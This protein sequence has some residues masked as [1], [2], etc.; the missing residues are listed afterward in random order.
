MAWVEPFVYFGSAEFS[1]RLL[2]G[3]IEADCKP[4]LVISTSAKPAGRGWRET[5]TPVAAYAKA[6]GLPV[7]T[8]KSLKH[9]LPQELTASAAVFG[10][11][12]AFGKIIPEGLLTLYPQGII[13]VHPSLLP[14]YRGPAPIAY[15]LMEGA[16]ETGVSIIKLDA[17]VDHGLM[18]AQQSLVIND[19]DDAV[20]LEQRLASLALELLLASV[21]KYLAGELSLTTQRHAQATYSHIVKRAHGQADWSQTAEALNNKRRAF[22]PWPGLWT[23][24]QGKRLKLIQTSCRQ[25]DLTAPGKVQ[26]IQSD[27]VIGCGERT[28]LIVKTIQLESGRVQTAN[29]FVR[30]RKDFINSHLP[31]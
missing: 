28:A 18:L 10:L 31:S 25:L 11:L 8:V 2:A 23:T 16:K 19:N 20:G 7:V 4:A 27:L 13:N 12:A 1:R 30:G 26:L 15:A 22:T 9:G 14:R 21:P 3:L 6:V 29:D 5:P 17:E 24:W